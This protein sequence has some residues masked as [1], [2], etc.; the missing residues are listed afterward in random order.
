MNAVDII[1]IFISFFEKRGHKRIPNSPL[2]PEN[3]PTT[4]FTSSGM[5]PLVP[6]LLGEPH[7]QGVRLVN[8]QNCFRAVDMDEVGDTNHTTFFRMLG[9]WSLGDYFKNEE[10]PWLWEFLTKQLGLPKEKLFIT[11]FS[12]DGSV[13]FDNE[14]EKIWKEIFEKEKL[15]PKIYKGDVTKNWWSRSGTPDNMPVGEPGGPDTEVY[16]RFDD[17]PAGEAGIEHGSKCGGDDPT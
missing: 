1:N 15:E 10:I 6:Y 7:P 17:P 11:V 16:F 4:L 13:E 5:Q 14:S 9:N 8:V 3:D 2:V 12:G